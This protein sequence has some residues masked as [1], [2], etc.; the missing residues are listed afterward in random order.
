VP[1]RRMQSLGSGVYELK[2]SDETS[3]YRV[4]YLAKIENVIHVLH[5]FEKSSRKTDRR[6]LKI[7]T[8]RLAKVRQRLE[9]RRKRAKQNHE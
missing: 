5:C 3:W 9:E 4:V 7:A 6:D 2:E 1:A 8:E